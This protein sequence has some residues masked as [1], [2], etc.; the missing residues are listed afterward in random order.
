MALHYR[1]LFNILYPSHYLALHHKTSHKLYITSYSLP[2]SPTPPH[3][4]HLL[5]ST[6]CSLHNILPSTTSSLLHRCLPASAFSNLLLPT[7][8][9]SPH[10]LLLT[11]PPPA[12]HHRL[13]PIVIFPLPGS[14]HYLCSLALFNLTLSIT[15]YPH[16]FLQTHTSSSIPSHAFHQFPLPFTTF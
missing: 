4:L 15:L 10:H 16:H 12:L 7:T 2:Y 6:T 9:C 14:L 8:S 3:P 13:I 1:L 5:L 11:T